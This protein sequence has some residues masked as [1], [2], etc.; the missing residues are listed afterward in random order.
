MLNILGG[1][2]THGYLSSSLCTLLFPASLSLSVMLSSRSAFCPPL[3]APWVSI[4]NMV[5]LL[6]LDQR[7]PALIPLFQLFALQ[8]RPLGETE[9]RDRKAKDRQQEDAEGKDGARSQR[10]ARRRRIMRE[11]IHSSCVCILNRAVR[12]FPLCAKGANVCF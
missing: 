9:D 11:G 5:I 7:P 8:C 1:S 4:P 2:V 3:F 12:T 10:T 6:G